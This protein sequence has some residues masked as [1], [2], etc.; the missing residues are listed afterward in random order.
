MSQDQNDLS[1]FSMMDLFR[2]EAGGQTQA[3]TDGL[4][5][6]ERGGAAPA[7]V[8][9][10]MRAAHSIKG[11]AAIVGLDLV[12]QMAHAMEDAFIAAQNQR[13]ELTPARIDV[14]LAAV[15]LIVQV[16]Q[17]SES[18]VAAWLASQA[19]RGSTLL[20]SLGT[21]SQ[22]QSAPPA[23]IKVEAPP[24]D[25]AAAMAAMLQ[26]EQDQSATAS[27]P[28]SVP[29]RTSADNFDNLLALASQ[30]RINAHQI[31]PFIGAM[32]RFKRNQGAMFQAIEQL[33]DAVLQSGDPALIDRSLQAL[34][35]T[36]P[37][38]QFVF[39]HLADLENYERRLLTVSKDMVDEVLALRM[40]PFRDGVQAFPRMVRDLARSLGKEAQL[41]IEGEETLVD[42]DILAKIESPLNHML[43][44][45]VDHGLETPAERGAAGKAPAGSITMDCDPP[46]L[47]CCQH[48]DQRRRRVAS[49]WKKFA[50]A[51]VRAQ[52]WPAAAM[53][54]G[55]VGARAAG[56]P[57]PA[58]F[59]P[60]RNHQRHFRPRSRSRHR[61]A[62][63]FA[64]TKRQ[65][66][67]WRSEPGQRH[68]HLRS[69]CR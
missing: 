6:M 39:E 49:T 24:D 34:Q 29:A 64:R 59:Q 65:Q 61:P 8:D 5:A 15:D 47:A 10:L 42:R 17:Q 58:R 62:R 32:Q 7:T 60:E 21:L 14:L 63:R 35:K 3:L 50:H 44:N 38:K 2:M 54:D 68:A 66:C 23:P 20:S 40:R 16:A 48:R 25:V 27:V 45:A 52:D 33:H 43:R 30:S 51:V 69:P 28:A 12:V 18:E 11:A 36:H 57:V 55:H 41:T 67:G 13:L 26:F 19:A 56:V 31:H 53:A 37:L 4:L 46:Q 1:Q 22:L 9:A